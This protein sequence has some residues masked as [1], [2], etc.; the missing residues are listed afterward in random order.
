MRLAAAGALF[1][2][3]GALVG[4]ACAASRNVPHGTR[5][6]A[7]PARTRRRVSIG[8]GTIF[9]GRSAR[10]SRPRRII[11]MRSIWTCSD[12]RRSSSGSGPQR[13]RPARVACP[14]GCSPADPEQIGVRQAAVDELAAADDGVSTWRLDGVLARGARQREIERLLA[15]AEG[16]VRSAPMARVIKAATI[17]ILASIWMLIAHSIRGAGLWLVPFVAGVSLSFALAG[18][19]HRAFDRAGA[20]Q[21]AMAGTRRCSHTS[22][23]WNLRVGPRCRMCASGSPPTASLRL[24]ACASLNRI[25]GFGELRD[26]AAILHFP[27]QAVTLWDF[28][29]LFALERWRRVRRVPRAR[30]DRRARRSSTRSAAL[31]AAR[32]DNPTWAQPERRRTRRA[33][34]RGAWASADPRR[35]GASRTTCRSVRPERCCWS[36]GRTCPARAR[37]CARSA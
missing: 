29:V 23:R 10:Q 19:I 2:V 22:R 30:L 9:H 28:H 15:W 34:R 14:N 7:S 25:L 3:F 20:G 31:A 35:A 5:R 13:R 4:L 1:A 36:P 26:G 27:I 8:A 16:P 17:I 37:C 24:P 11:R 18:R 21:Q 6:S 12:A 32:R 33:R